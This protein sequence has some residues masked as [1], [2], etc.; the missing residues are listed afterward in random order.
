MK[1]RQLT[2]EKPRENT[3]EKYPSEKKRKY[4]LNNL[5]MYRRMRK[6]ELTYT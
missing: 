3:L 1:G 5:Y 4:V 6:N 2:G